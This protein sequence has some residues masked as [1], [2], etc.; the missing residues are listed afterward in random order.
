M[1][2]LHRIWQVSH[3][4]AGMRMLESCMCKN[5]AVV[6]QVRNE[7]TQTQTHEHTQRERQRQTHTH[8]HTLSLSHRYASNKEAAM[9]GV[10]WVQPHLYSLQK[11][12]V[13]KK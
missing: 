12:K 4:E 1:V 8:T 13:L 2:S 3:V 9:H 7:Q 6:K 10:Q 11:K 5:M